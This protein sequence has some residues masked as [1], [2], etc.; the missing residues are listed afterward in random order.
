[1]I[2]SDRSPVSRKLS[3]ISIK[4]DN[5]I[6]A[7]QMNTYLAVMGDN[8]VGPQKI[9]LR[10]MIVNLLTKVFAEVVISRSQF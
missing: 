8:P 1:M 5:E 7:T 4:L 9:P 2:K 6:R 3:N 10:S